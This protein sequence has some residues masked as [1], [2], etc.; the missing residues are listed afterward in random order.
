MKKIIFIA[1]VLLTFSCKG[2]GEEAIGKVTDTENPEA[3]VNEGMP[4]QVRTPVALGESLFNGKGNCVACHQVDQKVIGPS[5]QDIAS[6]YKAKNGNI[7][8]FLVE[9]A[10][11]IVDP[12]QYEVM[13]TNFV[14]TKAMSE[15]ELKGLEAYIYSKLQ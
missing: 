1:I 4:V 3:T 9:D 13:K 14:I 10:A 15:E 8:A 12:S 11:P 2:K 5:V 6:I 7:I